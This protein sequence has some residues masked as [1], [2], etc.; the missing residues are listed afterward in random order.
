M[1]YYRPFPNYPGYQPNR[2]WDQISED[3]VLEDLEYLQQMYPTYAKRYQVRVRD[4]LNRMDYDGSMIYD[5]YPDKWQ[6][7]RLVQSIITILKNEE[8]GMNSQQLDEMEDP[9][10]MWI[11]ELVTV[12]LYYEILT[13]RQ[14][15]ENRRFF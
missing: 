10:W 5:Q 1:D 11:Q 3:R 14:R 7:D 4:I 2:N 13:R 12:L 8:R 6:L 15:R 9:K